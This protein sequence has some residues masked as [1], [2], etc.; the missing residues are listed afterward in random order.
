MGINIGNNNK[1]EESII[2]NN[3]TT[4]NKEQGKNALI[5]LIIELSI[6][7]VGGLIVAYVV[8]KFGWNK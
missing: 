1:I 2:G 3:N 4:N 6:A 7:I 8:Y 5:K